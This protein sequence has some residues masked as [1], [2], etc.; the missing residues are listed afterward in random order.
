MIQQ[1]KERILSTHDLTQRSTVAAFALWNVIL[2]STH[3]LTQR[4]TFHF[5]VIIR[6]KIFQLTT[7]RRGRPL[8]VFC[9]RHINGFQLTTSRRGRQVTARVPQ[10]ALNL[11]THDLTQRST[12]AT[13]I[14]ILDQ[15][16]STHDLTQRSTFSVTKRTRKSASFNSRPHAEVDSTCQSDPKM[17]DLSTH[18]LTQRSTGTSAA[19]NSFRC[20]S[21]HDLTQRSTVRTDFF[22]KR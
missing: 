8:M 1:D 2:L 19:G 21:T 11:S 10:I 6:R 4:S 9:G 17:K 3:D 16:L 15:I 5:C 12:F 20:L 7:S 22:V 18:D 13:T 14:Q